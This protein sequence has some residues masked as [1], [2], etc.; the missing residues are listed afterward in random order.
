MTDGQLPWAFDLAGSPEQMAPP[1]DENASRRQHRAAQFFLGSG[2][3]LLA[4]SLIVSV[5]ESV[6][7]YHQPWSDVASIAH[8]SHSDGVSLNA[9]IALALFAISFLLKRGASATH[10]RGSELCAVL[11]FLVAF[12]PALGHLY[13]AEALTGIGSFATAGVLTSVALILLSFGVIARPAA[14]PLW[15]FAAGDTPGGLLVRRLI[16]QVTVLL[17]FIGWVR[18]LGQEHGLY[19]WKVGL[20]LMIGASITL[21]VIGVATTAVALNNS[22]ADRDRAEASLR[23]HELRYRLIVD[24]TFD[25]IVISQNG[26]I[27]DANPGYAQMFGYERSELIGRS[28]FDL[29]AEEVRDFVRERIRAGQGGGYDVIGVRKTAVA[30]RLTQSCAYMDKGITRF[31]SRHCAIPPS[32]ASWKSSFGNRRRW[33]RSGDWPVVSRMISTTC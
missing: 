2:A 29:V 20:V 12:V 32:N 24:A 4:G 1:A 33:K 21:F 19:D 18:V 8:I 22:S 31:A 28:V 10:L 9:L 11:M 14:G 15:R 30:S 26:F 25:G 27:K 23:E 13:R 5:R 6:V 16:P 17:V 3:M 7:V